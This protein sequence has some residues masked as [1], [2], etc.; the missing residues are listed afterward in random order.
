MAEISFCSFDQTQSDVLLPQMFEILS[1][2]MN[3]FYKEM[4]ALGYCFDFSH[5]Y[6]TIT[7]PDFPKARRLKTLGENYTEES[8]TKRVLMNIRRGETEEVSQEKP[9]DL[10]F[11]GDIIN[12]QT[13]VGYKA[14]YTHFVFGL[15]I[16]M[17]RPTSNRQMQFL[18]KDDLLRLDKLIAENNFVVDND[19]DTPDKLEEYEASADKEITE[20]VEARERLKRNLSIARQTNSVSEEAELKEHI[21]AVSARISK[22]RKDKR[23]CLRVRER[24]P[25]IN[26]RM[27]EIKSEIN[28]ESKEVKDNELIRRR[29]GTNRENEP[30]RS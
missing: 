22:L 8:L 13:I 19:I 26:E 12:A 6:T 7:H 15:R 27:T 24:F 2:N 5:K 23:L 20:L 10:F 4:K 25:Q 28:H 11:D 3:N 16:V 1:T 30:K 18:L 9:E 17:E 29:S 21:T 14:T